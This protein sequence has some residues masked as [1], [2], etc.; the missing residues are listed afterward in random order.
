VLC[1]CVTHIYITS[2]SDVNVARIRLVSAKMAHILP[3]DLRSKVWGHLLLGS[4]LFEDRSFNS[5]LE[6]DYDSQNPTDLVKEI[7][8]ACNAITSDVKL[9]LYFLPHYILLLKGRKF[10]LTHNRLN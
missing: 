5:W 1:V 7:R 3:S 6:K 4:D 9:L 8:S 2:N 10:D